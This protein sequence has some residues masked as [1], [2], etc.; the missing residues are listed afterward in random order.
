MQKS[1]TA[2]LRKA[3]QHMHNEAWYFQP[4]LFHK[5]DIWLASYPR[6]G[7]HFVRFILVSARHFIQHGYFPQDLSGMKTIPDVH[8]GRL[9]FALERPRIIKTHFPFEPRYHRI[10]HLIRDPRD[11]VI[12]YYHYS[13][14]LPHLFT[15]PVPPGYNFPQFLDLFLRGKVWPGDIR[16][17]TDSYRQRSGDVVY[18]CIR[19]ESL[20]N[21][22]ITEYQRLLNAAC[23]AL[24]ADTLGALIKHTSFENMRR[25]HR[26][27]TARAG[28]VE[29]NPAYILRKG[30]AGQHTQVLRAR[31]RKRVMEE[32]GEYLKDYGYD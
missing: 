12:S 20:L 26:P 1:T 22:P 14:G 31:A 32:L 9:E 30:Q 16:K 8:G 17:H 2:Y 24:P 15:E 28:M 21:D 10:I 25:L 27:D 5:N 3:V 18:A 13:Q 6:S 23:I 7:S 19:Y 11:L 4:N 29:S